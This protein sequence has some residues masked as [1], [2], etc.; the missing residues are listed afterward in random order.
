MLPAPSGA[1]RAGFTLVEVIVVLVILAI[2]AAIAIP[3]L[4]GYI[5]K[6][7]DKQYIAMAR[8]VAVAMRTVMD[9][10]YADGTLGK[11]LPA[12]GDFSDYLEN[13]GKETKDTGKK[14]FSLGTLGTY[15]SSDYF[16]Y[17]N[18]AVDLLS[19][20]KR[21][22]MVQDPNFWALYFVGAELPG[23]TMFNADGFYFLYSPEGQGAKKPL[24]IVTYKVKPVDISPGA[25]TNEWGAS[26]FWK[27]D[28][29]PYDANAGYYVYHLIWS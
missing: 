14:L 15:D 22:T 19:N 3:A 9:E 10:A 8:N 13:G 23:T 24:I 16:F 21:F 11:G 6:A 7:Q 2:L 5:D 27:S 25:N 20:N 29:S 28:E 1:R 26:S 18:K 4:T 12:V 17:T